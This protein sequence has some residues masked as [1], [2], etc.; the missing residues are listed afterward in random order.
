MYIQINSFF[1]C[2][3]GHQGRLFY[4]YQLCHYSYQLWQ[5]LCNFLVIT[6]ARFSSVHNPE[7]IHDKL[8]FIHRVKLRFLSFWD[9]GPQTSTKAIFSPAEEDLPWVFLRCQFWIAEVLPSEGGQDYRG[10]LLH[11]TSSY[12]IWC[13]L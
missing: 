5:W 3:S 2:L 8:K 4:S 6:C 9:L 12:D 1:I 13:R 11:H 7:K 10:K